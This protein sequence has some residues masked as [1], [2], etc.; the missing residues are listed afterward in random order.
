[1]MD[2]KEYRELVSE[3]D[4]FLNENLGVGTNEMGDLSGEALKAAVI[5]RLKQDIVRQNVRSLDD[6]Q[7]RE[8]LRSAEEYIESMYYR[9]PRQEDE[10]SLESFKAGVI[11]GLKRAA[12]VQSKDYED[13]LSGRREAAV[14]GILGVKERLR[15]YIQSRGLRSYSDELEGMIDDSVNEI[16]REYALSVEEGGEIRDEIASYVERLMLK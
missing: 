6:E 7:G 13:E 3:W 12:S 4:R 8:F 15:G 16:V 9:S 11:A 2:R 1:M 10:E 14:S 5:E